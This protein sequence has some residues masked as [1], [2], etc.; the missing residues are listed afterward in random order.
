MNFRR[1]PAELV[2]VVLALLTACTLFLDLDIETQGAVN[3]ALVTLGGFVV[4]ALVA[5]EKALPMLTGL[6]KAVI[7]VM[8]AF[9]IELAPN[10]QA[11]VMAILTVVAGLAER[12]RVVA[13]APPPSGMTRSHI[14]RQTG[15]SV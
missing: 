11:G 7:A 5:A 15:G 1:E 13:P 9:G 4:A 8:L 10:I 6:G 2:G 3:A 12:D 14:Q